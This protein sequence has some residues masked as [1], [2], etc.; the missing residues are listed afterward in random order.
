MF[1]INKSLITIFYIISFNFVANVKLPAADFAALP[2]IKIGEHQGRPAFINS[3]TGE[4]FQPMGSSYLPEKHKT[5]SPGVYVSDDAESALEKMAEGGFTVVRIWSYHGHW[6]NRKE[7][8]FAM[9]GPDYRNQNTPE[10]WQPYVDNIVDFITRASRRGIYVHLVID[11]EPDTPFYRDRVN[12]GY[13]DVEGFI[14]REYLT[15]GSLEAKE[16]YIAELIKNFRQRNPE[17]LSTI[18]A[19]EIRN[20]IH[21][22]TAQAP[23]NKTEGVVETAAGHYDMGSPS[24]RQACFNENVLLFLSR[25]AKALKKADP[26]A[27]ATT[28]TFAYLPVHKEG[29]LEAGLLPT[30]ME[31]TRWPILPAV[32]VDSDLDFVS[33][34]SYY[35]HD[36]NR[37]LQSS[38]FDEKFLKKKPFI[39]GE[40]GAHRHSFSNVDLA[41]SALLVYRDD[42]LASGFRGAYLFTWDTLQHTRWTMVEDDAVI[43]ETLRLKK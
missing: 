37:A 31:D 23:F 38:G 14:H 3:S 30:D 34:H 2:R 11:R 6:E 8:L 16:I 43:Y 28:S 33:F 9:E 40:F 29:M 39:C 22:D 4:V 7:G 35:P 10:L 18:F 32:L 41:A 25:A 12:T 1:R 15:E 17:L 24:S 42:I 20:E 27:L 5:F 13:P 19:Y 36:W 21:A 26:E